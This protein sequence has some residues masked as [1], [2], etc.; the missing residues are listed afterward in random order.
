VGKMVRV[1]FAHALRPMV[2]RHVRRFC[3][4]VQRAFMDAA[5]LAGVLRFPGYFA[6]PVPWQ[7]AFWAPPGMESIDISR[8]AKAQVDQIAAGLRSPQ[9]IAAARGRDLEEVYR[10]IKEAR[11]LAETM[12]LAFDLSAV[13]TAL[14]DN[15]AALEGQNIKTSS[16]EDDA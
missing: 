2:G 11:D 4:P 8:E 14:A 6:D 10:E 9:E 15:P 13:S 16:E 12:G 7:R 1:D 5:V 3:R